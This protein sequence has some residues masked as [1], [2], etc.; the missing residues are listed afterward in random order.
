MRGVNRIILIG[1]IGNDPERRTTAGGVSVCNASL[2]TS[3]S[4]KDKKT[5]QQN[6]K[7]EWHKLVFFDKLAE[8]VGN[9]VFKGSKIY[10]EGAL[11]TTK[12]QD[13]EGKDR[14]TTE[15]VVKDMVMLDANPAGEEQAKRPAKAAK[16]DAPFE[17]TDFDDEIPI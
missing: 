16:Q 2:A 7:T 13:K 1:N 6:E 15:I 4:W 8:I 17:F 9:H 12:W 5:G 3:E 14:Y 10:V 11:R